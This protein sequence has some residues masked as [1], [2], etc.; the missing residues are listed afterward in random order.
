MPIY[1]TPWF[2]LVF[3]GSDLPYNQAA[4]RG[5]K[6]RNLWSFP[7]FRFRRAPRHWDAGSI[8]GRKGRGGGKGLAKGNARSLIPSQREHSIT[9]Q[10]EPPTGTAKILEAGNANS[11]PRCPLGWFALLAF[12]PGT[13][14]T[15]TTRA[16]WCS[17]RSASIPPTPRRRCATGRGHAVTDPP[18]NFQFDN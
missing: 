2:F 6:T 8:G 11:N 15:G 7:G 3:G 10:S 1:Q 13:P 12:Y 14:A 4:A 16:S 5:L 18:F 17:G 9:T